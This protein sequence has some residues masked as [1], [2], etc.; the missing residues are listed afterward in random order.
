MKVKKKGRGGDG[1]DGGSTMVKEESRRW[2]KFFS[3]IARTYTR[4]SFYKS[5]LFIFLYL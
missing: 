3:S 5:F 2:K 4:E 1:G